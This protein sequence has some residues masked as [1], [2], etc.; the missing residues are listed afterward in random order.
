MIITSLVLTAFS[1]SV[2]AVVA[3]FT[4]FRRLSPFDES[5]IT[6]PAHLDAAITAQ[7]SRRV[8]EL[9]KR[10]T[11]QNYWSYALLG[12]ALLAQI[13]ALAMDHFAHP[14][15]TTVSILPV[16]SV[17]FAREVSRRR[18]AERELDA[19][20]RTQSSVPRA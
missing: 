18:Y 11:Q 16:L 9:Q 6:D 12:I 2:I 5:D 19:Y 4:P 20:V 3:A 7:R 10:T 13:A 8:A 14:S 15:I 17:V 1:L